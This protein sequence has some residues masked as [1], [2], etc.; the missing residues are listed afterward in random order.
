MSEKNN[1][2]L[3]TGS[4][5]TDEK[6]IRYINLKLALLGFPTVAASTDPEF[7]ELTAALLQ[8]QHETDRL[9]AD[10]LCPADQRI[11]VFLN[12]YLKETGPAIKLPGRTF[13]LDQYGLA[14]VLSLPPDRDEFISEHVRSYRVKQGVLHNP[15]SDRK[16]TRLNSS[17]RC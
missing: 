7:E 10:Y 5:L 4:E 15:Q 6:T 11:Q 16:S 14:R 12:D 3:G 1:I 8:R 13:V 17:H 2:G 9:L